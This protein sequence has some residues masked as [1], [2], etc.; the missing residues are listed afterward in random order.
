VLLRAGDKA[1]GV[2]HGVL[3]SLLAGIEERT[4]MRIS[5]R[6]L[7][8]GSILGACAGSL[9]R[10]VGD[11]TRRETRAA[12]WALPRKRTYS[13]VENEWI[14]LKDGTRLGAR[15]WLPE[16]ATKSPVPVVLE[17]LPYRK[18]DVTRS[19]DNTTG[20]RL[21]S[22]GIAFARVDIRGSGDSTGLL[23]GEYTRQEQADAVEVI[24]WLAQQLWST[25]SVGMRGIS[26][27]GFNTF[28]TAALAPPQLK[29][30]MPCCFTD[31]QFTDDAHYYGR[32]LSNPNYY[33]GVM[34]QTVLGGPPDPAIVGDRW[35]AMWME[36]LEGL[37]PI[38][39]EW[40]SHQR[41][42]EH[43]KIG[44][45]AVDYSRIKC[46]VY[47]VGGLNDH[48]IDVNARV[49]AHL[50]VPRKSL[51]GP[52]AHNWPDSGD[53][54][55]SLDWTTEEV[56]WW[57]HWLMGVDTGIMEEPQ[58][59]VYLCDRT[60][61]EVYPDDIPGRWIAESE[62]PSANIKPAVW[63]L[64]ADGLSDRPKEQ[65][66]LQVS[67]KQVVG[68]LRGEP[69]AFFFPTDL[70]QEQSPD[71]S[72]SLVFD[73]AP[74][75]QAL[76]VVGNPLLRIRVSVDV[77]IGHLAVRLE[78]VAPDGSSW[79]LTAG[80][81]NL[82]HRQSSEHPTPLVPGQAVDIEI[83][84]VFMSKRVAAGRR[85]R[86]ALSENFWP[87]VWPSPQAATPTITTGISSLLLP[88]RSPRA[89][90][91]EPNVE[92]VRNQVRDRL[93]V[94]PRGGI[95]VTRS[96]PD[97]NGLVTIRKTFMPVEAVVPDI[98]TVI[99]RGWTPATFEIRT[100]DPNSCRWTGGF[101]TRF[102]RDSWNVAIRGGFELTSS[103]DNFFIKEFVQA[104]ESDKIV[105][106]RHWEH[107]IRRDLM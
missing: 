29:A 5:R 27:G 8:A 15:L 49:M 28:Q 30:I 97:A 19:R 25:G 61:V 67:G 87:L 35:R 72:R 62:W 76:D 20:D 44:S 39:S 10:A 17:Y 102:H 26:W 66:Q 106:E 68:M 13:I 84:L 60:A 6:T 64:N 22:H 47:A 37:P 24:A 12:R 75:T 45:V 81:L 42:D 77:P 88:V 40:T 1:S 89:T 36:R 18:R 91:E 92:I 93:L 82:S 2:L 78:E 65:R 52:W 16:G 90:E 101:E 32:A 98:G 54:G 38:L 86:V 3:R 63:Y 96:G 55:P 43:W 21:A 14:T 80:L 53:P 46:P 59:R 104:T 9:E 31:N 50:K 85:L 74:L 58:F 11:S 105:F 41:F 23:R 95:D 79:M 99:N 94:N 69:D 57:V 4:A 48:F 51:I 103:V 100:G 73:S 71:D 70:P 7:L 107:A 83:P 34:F 33:W 56:R